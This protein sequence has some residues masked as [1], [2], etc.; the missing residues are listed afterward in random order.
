MKSIFSIRFALG[1]SDQMKQKSLREL[2]IMA[3]T[4]SDYVVNYYQ[5]LSSVDSKQSNTLYQNGVMF[6]YSG[7]NNGTKAER[8]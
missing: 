6:Q 2:Q 8:V 3:K 4:R 7:G 5:L 1:L